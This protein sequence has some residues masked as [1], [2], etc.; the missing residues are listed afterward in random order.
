MWKPPACISRPW[1]AVT[2][3]C[4][5]FGLL[6]KKLTSLSSVAKKLAIL[7]ISIADCKAQSD[8]LCATQGS[9]VLLLY[10]FLHSIKLTTNCRSTIIWLSKHLHSPTC[11]TWYRSGYWLTGQQKHQSNQ[12]DALRS[13]TEMADCSILLT[14]LVSSTI[15][16]MNFDDS[17]RFWISC[18]TS[19]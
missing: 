18:F 14:S 11:S 5:R 6:L 13:Q 3:L 4:A 2:K 17:T 7:G 12:A 16:D 19:S 1:N 10:R 15:T 9:R 8:L